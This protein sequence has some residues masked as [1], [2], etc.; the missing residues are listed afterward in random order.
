MIKSFSGATL[1]VLAYSA[2][3]SLNGHVSSVQE[4]VVDS[5]MFEAVGQTFF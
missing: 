1:R 2:S 5:A 3:M 4:A